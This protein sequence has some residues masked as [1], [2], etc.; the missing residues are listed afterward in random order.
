MPAANRIPLRTRS[1]LRS[2]SRRVRSTTLIGLGKGC[3]IERLLIRL[4]GV[5]IELQGQPPHLA[6][7]RTDLQAQPLQIGSRRQI[8]QVPDPRGDRICPVAGQPPAACD[9][10]RHARKLV[11]V[12]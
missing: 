7:Q 4:A 10:R 2:A 8:H 5:A 12:N 11:A 1:A 3:T 6:I 9:H